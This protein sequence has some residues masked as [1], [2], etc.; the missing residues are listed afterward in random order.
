[1][2]RRRPSICPPRPGVIARLRR[3]APAAE[4][5]TTPAQL[6]SGH[7]PL[8]RAAPAPSDQTADNVYYVKLKPPKVQAGA[9]MVPRIAWAPHR[10]VGQQ[11]ERS[12]SLPTSSAGSS[13]VTEQSQNEHSDPT[14]LLGALRSLGLGLVTTGH[15]EGAAGVAA[16][17]LPR[18][19]HVT[20]SLIR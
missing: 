18:P 11:G 1:M 6:P 16:P 20:D 15:I 14:R 13:S 12:W 8:Q 10:V 9:V 5:Q 17:V 19:P 2:C 3:I 4:Q 7:P